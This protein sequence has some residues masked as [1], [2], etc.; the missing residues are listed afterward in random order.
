MN[1]QQK[2]S[3]FSLIESLIAFLVIS[4]GMLGVGAL[5]SLAIG[6]TK[7]AADRSTASIH[8]SALLSRLRG[9]DAFWQTIPPTFDITISSTGVI[10]D[11]AAGGDAAALQAAALDCAA[12][13]CNPL[14]IASFDLKTWAQNGSSMGVDGGMADRLPA[15][16][17]RIRR[18]G[19]DFPVML[20]IAVTWSEKRAASSLDMSSTY[21]S[22]TGT[23]ANSQR[24]FTHTL[25]AR[26]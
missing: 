10:A 15:P 12:N 2:Q 4:F 18:I 13:V 9:N 8:S 19:I 25:R 6:G 23:A 11:T 20:Q 17:A 7:V 22:A 24:N 3:G 21:Y 16:A 14:Q 5:N 1:L 26:P